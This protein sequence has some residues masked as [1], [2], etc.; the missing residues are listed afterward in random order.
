MVPRLMVSATPKIKY[1]KTL[2]NRSVIAAHG[3]IATMHR[4]GWADPALRALSMALSCKL[5]STY[6][7]LSTMQGTGVLYQFTPV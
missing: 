2:A 7:T 1:Y 3:R 5:T 4:K 6:L